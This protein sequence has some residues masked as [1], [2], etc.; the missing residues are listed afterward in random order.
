MAGGGGNDEMNP[1]IAYVDLFSSI[2]LVLLLFVLIMFVNIG[3]YMQFNSKN[4]TASEANTTETT[5]ETVVSS[6]EVEKKEEDKKEDEKRI[7]IENPI[8]VSTQRETNNTTLVR[9]GE[10]EGNILTKKAE[11]FAKADFNEE[12]LII[13]FKNN[14]FFLAK[15]TISQIAA[16]MEKQ[17]KNNPK[18][19]FYLSVGDSKKLISS[20]QTKQVSLGRILSARNAL[21]GIPALADKVKIDYKPSTEANYEFGFLKIDVR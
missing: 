1:F 20:T 5:S 15:D 4:Q 17:L 8:T 3:Y 21:Q 16:F 19:Q 9:G 11:K 7:V 18:A 13:A 12:D 6:I 10:V 14:E 2:I